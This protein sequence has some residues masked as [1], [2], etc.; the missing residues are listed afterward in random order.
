MSKP[1]TLSPFAQELRSA[2]EEVHLTQE[3]VARHLGTSQITYNRWERGHI[4]PSPGYVAKLARLFPNIH[5]PAAPAADFPFALRDARKSLGLS[6]EQLAVRVGCSANSIW[7][8]ESGAAVPRFDSILALESALGERL[9]ATRTDKGREPTPEDLRLIKLHEAHIMVQRA[10]ADLPI[11]KACDWLI[12]CV[13]DYEEELEA[14]TAA[15]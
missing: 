14:V 10:F 8:W 9:S 11:D 13:D 2:R 3:A 4:T 12:R 15:A 1:K 6:Q 7:K 5:L